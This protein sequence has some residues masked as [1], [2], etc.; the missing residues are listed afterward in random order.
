MPLEVG[1]QK[2]GMNIEITA[3]EGQ[4]QGARRLLAPVRHDGELGPADPARA[5]DP[6]RADREQGAR[7]GARRR[8]APTSSR[9]RRCRPRWPSTRRSFNDLY[10]AMVKSGETGGV[11]DDVLLRLADMIETRGRPARQDQVG[12]DLSG[13]GRRARRAD[14]VGDAAVRRAAV[15]DDLR[16]AG[17]HAAAADPDPA[18]RCRTS[19]RSTGTSS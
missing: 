1:K 18:R 9:A 14:H 11:L 8:S 7:E 5:L 13:R 12:D 6:G 19:S 16:A 17:R 10:V 15:Q 4:A 2:R 3:Q